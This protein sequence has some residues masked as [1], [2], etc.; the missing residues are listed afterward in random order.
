MNTMMLI[1]FRKG[2]HARAPIIAS[3]RKYV[4]NPM[5]TGIIEAIIGTATVKK[6]RRDWTNKVLANCS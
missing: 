4:S 6:G 2:F 5:T 1:E 3:P